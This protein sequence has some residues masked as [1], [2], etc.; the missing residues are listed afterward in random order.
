MSITIGRKLL[1]RLKDINYYYCELEN[2]A[3]FC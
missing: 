2:L 3:H 1:V